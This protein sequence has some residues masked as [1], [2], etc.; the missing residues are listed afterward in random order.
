MSVVCPFTNRNHRSLTYRKKSDLERVW[1][2]AEA[3]TPYPVNVHNINDK[4][5]QTSEMLHLV[6]RSV[7]TDVLRQR[8]SSQEG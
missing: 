3:E 5:I 7:I 2:L 6:D 1:Q 8:T 4:N